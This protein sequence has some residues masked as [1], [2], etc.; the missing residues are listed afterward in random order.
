MWVELSIEIEVFVCFFCVV[1]LEVGFDEC[2]V[3]DYL[4]WIVMDD[5]FECFDGCI[6]IVC[7]EL[8]LF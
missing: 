2:M 7:F 8:V 5:L 1:L 3:C 6:V 4:G